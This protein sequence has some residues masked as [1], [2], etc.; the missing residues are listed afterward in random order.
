MKAELGPAGSRRCVERGRE[1]TGTSDSKQRSHQRPARLLVNFHMDLS[2]VTHVWERLFQISSGVIHLSRSY[3]KSD[4]KEKRFLETATPPGHGRP[5]PGAPSRCTPPTATTGDAIGTR[6]GIDTSLA[7]EM[8][9]TASGHAAS[10]VAC[11]DGRA[12]C[13]RLSAGDRESPQAR[14]ASGATRRSDGNCERRRA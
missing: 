5:F 12:R 1:E 4:T 3:G 2:A 9:T 10:A 14:T 7:Q 6:I 11:T 13:S 8:A